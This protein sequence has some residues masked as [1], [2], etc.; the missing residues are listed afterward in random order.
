MK[1]TNKLNLSIFLSSLVAIFIGVFIFKNL[2][3]LIHSQEKITKQ[4]HFILLLNKYKTDF[5]NLENGIR[6]YLLTGENSYLE[7]FSKAEG[8]VAKT[9]KDIRKH[10]GKDRDKRKKIDDVVAIQKKWVEKTVMPT[11]LA[12]RKL[13][14][15]LIDHKAFQDVFKQAK[16]NEITALIKN[17]IDNLTAKEN[18]VKEDIKKHNRLVTDKTK[19]YTAGGIFL[20]LFFIMLTL[21]VLGKKP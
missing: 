7:P 1:F 17:K 12:R 11:M 13:N 9:I 10:I 21:I 5:V 15:G 14:A 3:S 8:V 18:L 20:S 6:G 16:S 4:V 2:N 19:I